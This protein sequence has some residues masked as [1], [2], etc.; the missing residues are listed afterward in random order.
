MPDHVFLTLAPSHTMGRMV[1]LIVSPEYLSNGEKVLIIDDATVVTG[2]YNFS[3][4]AE[5]RNDENTLIIFDEQL[6]GDYVEH[7][8][9]LWA[10]T[11]R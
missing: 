3:S 8:Q 5:F 4:N 10:L 9:L 2:S 6:A 7:F 1:E 11:Q